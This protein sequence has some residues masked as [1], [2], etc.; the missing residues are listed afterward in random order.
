MAVSWLRV[1]LPDMATAL[2][3]VAITIT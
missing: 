2:T 3:T 1:M